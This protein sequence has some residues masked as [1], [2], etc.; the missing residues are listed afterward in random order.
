MDKLEPLFVIKMSKKGKVL[1]TSTFIVDYIVGLRL[2]SNLFIEL[3]EEIALDTAEYKPTKWLRYVDD[4]FVIWLH[5]PVTLQ[6]FLHH[7]NSR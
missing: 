5:E 7:F 1:L 3:V 2:Y 6:Q 4:A